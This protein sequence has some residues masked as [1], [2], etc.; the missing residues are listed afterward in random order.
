MGSIKGT[1]KAA[2]WDPKLQKAVVRT[3]PIPDPAPNQILV[4]LGSA[5][6]CHSDLMAISNPELVEPFTIGH[7]GA[8]YVSRV[9]TDCKDK[10]FKEGDPVGFLYM[11]GCCFECEGCMVHNMQCTNGKT[12]IAGFGGNFGFFQEYAAL[13]WQ[14]V[15]HLPAVLDP[16]RSSAIFC[17]G[18]TGR[19]Q[20]S[21]MQRLANPR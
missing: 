18:V 10:G 16:K 19:L 17:A 21:Q 13:D 11:N 8:G 3:I 15:I 2:Q 12:A 4:K 1:M 20:V 7:E 9:G 6:L 5:S 14:N